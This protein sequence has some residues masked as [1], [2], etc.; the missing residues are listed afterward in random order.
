MNIQGLV[1]DR[2]AVSPVI[3]AVLLV[4]IIVILAAVVG[5]YTMGQADN[6]GESAPSVEFTYEGTPN[7]QFTIMHDRGDTF[8][9]DAVRITYVEN[10]GTVASPTEGS[11]ISE[12]WP[13]G[14]V[15]TS[16]SYTTDS[17]VYQGTQIRVFWKSPETGTS[18]RIGAYTVSE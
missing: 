13:S 8:E 14:E 18:S 11:R 9:G 16:S 7:D 15:M 5:I 10:T 12:D 6:M 17:N 2:D 1:T 4:G 3:G